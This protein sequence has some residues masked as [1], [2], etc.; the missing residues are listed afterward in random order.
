MEFQATPLEGVFVLKPRVFEDDRGCFFEAFNRNTFSDAG[1]DIEFVQDNMSYSSYGVIRGL[2]FQKK[3]M[4]MAKLVSVPKGKVLDVC[5]DLRKD[6]SS[7][8][9]HFKIE[10]SEQNHLQLLIPRGF[11]HG[12]AVLENN[13]VFSYKCDNFYSKEHDTGIY[14]HDPNIGIDW[15]I[16][17]EDQILSEKD[18]NLPRLEEAP[19][20]F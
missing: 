9:Q 10:L 13:T 3:P 12:F 18:Q 19:P 17:K 14:L 4:A 8:L 6:S 16:P 7:Y 2:H 5:V 11:A 15:Q 20:E 1:I